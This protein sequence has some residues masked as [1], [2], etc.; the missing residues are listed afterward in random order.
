MKR[1]EEVWHGVG[2]DGMEDSNSSIR[3]THCGLV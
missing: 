1:K 3:W 2:W